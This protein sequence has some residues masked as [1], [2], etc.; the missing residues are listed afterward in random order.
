MTSTLVRQ[1]QQKAADLAERAP[2]KVKPLAVPPPGSGLKP[3]LGDHGPPIIGHSLAMIGDQLKFARERY[4]Q[5]GEV[6]WGG[7]LGTRGVF[8]LGPEAI[9]IVLTNRDKAFANGPGW[10]YFIGPFF[11]RGVMLL[12]F[13][14]HHHHRRIMQQAFTRDRLV[15]Y[16]DAMNPAIARGL[17]GWRPGRAFPLYTQAKQ[18]TLNLATEVF[19]GTHLGPEADRL[20]TAFIDTVH[21]GTAIVRADVPGG[22]WHRGLRGRRVLEEYFRSQLPAKRAGDGQDLFSVLCQAQSEDGDRFT[23]DDVVNHMIF[24]L[25]AAHDTSTITLAMMGYFLGKHPE[26]QERVRAESLALGKPA[27]EYDDLERLPSLDLVMKES[28]RLY[29]PVG[30]IVRQTVKDTDVLGHYIPAGT[31]VLLGIYPTQR[32]TPWWT[33]PDTFDPERFAEP[34]REDKSHRFAWMPF[35]GGVHKCIGLHFGGMEVKAIMHQL[36]QRYSWRVPAGYE[37][38]VSYGTGPMPADGLPVALEPLTG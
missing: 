24:V 28:L 20:T 5:F 32:M 3:V 26:W 6:Q 27:L 14:E 31:K 36:L 33:D 10:E 34:R 30:G 19:V 7:F 23:D 25:M 4:E 18:L 15:G 13:E 35:G 38:P 29:A 21:A 12:D 11:P 8:L 22:I 1:M 9:G 16:L 17:D 37:V 2:S